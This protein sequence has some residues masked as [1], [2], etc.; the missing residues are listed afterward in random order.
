MYFFFWQINTANVT[1]DLLIVHS[2]MYDLGINHAGL[3]RGL[4]NSFPLVPQ[5]SQHVYCTSLRC[6][7][8]KRVNR[9]DQDYEQEPIPRFPREHL[10]LTKIYTRATKLT[11]TAVS[12]C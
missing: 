1:H 8:L 2:F 7:T 12:T 11:K 4:L 6:N 10:S 5:S 9:T 3:D